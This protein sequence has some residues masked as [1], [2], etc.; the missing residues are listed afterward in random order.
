MFNRCCHSASVSTTRRITI[1]MSPD[2]THESEFRSPAD[3]VLSSLR[4]LC[5]DKIA[6]V[7]SVSKSLVEPAGEHLRGQSRSRETD[8]R[9]R[10][11]R[12]GRIRGRQT[13][14][15]HDLPQRCF[16]R[17]QQRR[18]PAVRPFQPD[19]RAANDSCAFRIT[20]FERT[21]GLSFNGS[22]ASSPPKN[23]AAVVL[24]CRIGHH[25]RR[26]NASRIDGKPM[27]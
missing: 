26:W 2:A 21:H 11:P 22:G 7:I 17:P 6:L 25:L 5:A 23:S 15:R 16:R 1:E 13:R 3:R 8:P 19:R 9:C 24:G 20:R 12:G 18:R 14:R 10:L 4:L 27:V